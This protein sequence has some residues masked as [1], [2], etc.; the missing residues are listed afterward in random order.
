MDS[1]LQHLSLCFLIHIFA[2]SSLQAQPRSGPMAPIHDQPDLPRVLLVGDSI[3]I[4]Y[5]VPVREMLKGRANV[6]RILE[7]GGPSSK[8]IQKLDQWL[9]KEKW[10]LIHFNWGLHDLKFMENNKRQVSL[11]DYEQN[12]TEI[13]D[14]LKQTGASLIWASTTPVP[15]GNLK[16]LRK[17]GDDLIYNL[18]A[19]RIMRDKQ[20]AVNDLFALANSQLD[21]I[22]RPENVHFTPDGSQLLAK[23]V[24][25]IITT[26]LTQIEKGNNQNSSPPNFVI[27]IADDHGEN[28]LGC[29]GNKQIRTPNV[30]RLATEGMR[31]TNA[32]LS[33]SSCSPSR[34]SILT[35]RYPHNTGAEDL[36]MPLPANQY[37][38]ARYLKNAGYYCASVGK[39]HLGNA[40]KRNWNQVTECQA[41][42]MAESTIE[43]LRNRDPKKP[44]L[45]WVAS[46]DP[47]RS[48]QEGA[49]EPPHSPESVRV[50]PYLPDHPKIRKELA[51]YYDEVSRFDKHIGQIMVELES[52]NAL[53]NTVI[54]YVS[55]NGMPFPRAKC[56]LYDSGIHTPL[57][58]RWPKN[59]P[60]GS[61]QTGLASSIDIAPTLMALAGIPQDTMEGENII[62][63]LRD[64]NTQLRERIYAEANWHDFEKFTRSVRSNQFKLIR[65]YYWDTPLWNSVDSVNSITWHGML[66]SK[67]AGKLTPSQSFL[68]N[69]ERPFEEF[70]DLD[71]DPFEQV[72]LVKDPHYQRILSGLRADLDNWRAETHDVMPEQRRQDGWTRRGNPLPHNQPWYDRFIEQGGKNNFDKF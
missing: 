13:V 21:Q 27:F 50:P 32:F 71:A 12:L 8:G 66:E 51:L 47:H 20:V 38:I 67:N 58:V 6:H 33:I 11:D 48:Y 26:K 23:Q 72:N 16:P 22:Q 42:V 10:D 29:Y 18:V 24:S 62:E 52:Q 63:M 41:E 2:G 53:E 9:G 36:H 70:Y 35:G 19:K 46:I 55:D 1:R 14:R 56:T 45:F 4:G 44:F 60:A 57:I 17:P 68:F 31:F 37:T 40:E 30:D 54:I 43:S 25:R 15:H 7:N 5:T 69:P 64:P 3:S 49:V 59:I 34:S 65:N 39:W 61:V 28:D